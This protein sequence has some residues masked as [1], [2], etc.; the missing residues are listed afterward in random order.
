MAWAYASLLF[1][2]FTVPVSA[3]ENHVAARLLSETEGVRPGQTF[4]VGLHLRMEPGWHTYWKEPGDSGMAT[5]IEWELPRG[6]T[7]GPI[8][9]PP[10]QKIESPPLVNYGYF[11][12]AFL[13]TSIRAPEKIGGRSVRLKAKVRWLECAEV[14]VP[15]QADLELTLPLSEREP[16]PSLEFAKLAAAPSQ[17]SQAAPA[18]MRSPLFSAA[19]GCLLLGLGIALVS[20]FLKFA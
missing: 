2:F 9:W 18:P 12:D 8:E 17:V 19:A 14:C 3:A 4:R 7:A 11:G 13:V 20:F 10:P 15:G 5:R 6:F 16:A 1:V